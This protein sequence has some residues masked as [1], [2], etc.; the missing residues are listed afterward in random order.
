[1]RSKN[2]IGIWDP[3][4]PFIL[5]AFV[6]SDPAEFDDGGVFGVHAGYFHGLSGHRICMQSAGKNIAEKCLLLEFNADS[7]VFKVG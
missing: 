6:G 4:A 1:M 7:V 5:G 2:E 3:A